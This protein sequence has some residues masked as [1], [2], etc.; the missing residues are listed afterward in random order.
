MDTESTAPADEAVEALAIELANV[1]HSVSHAEH[2]PIEILDEMFEPM[3]VA[4]IAVAE[5]VLAKG[6]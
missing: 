2:A 4:W 5:H 1:A 3:R 6:A